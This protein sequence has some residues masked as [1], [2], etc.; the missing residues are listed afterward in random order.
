[1]HGISGRHL[2]NHASRLLFAQGAGNP[3]ASTNLRRAVRRGG[4]ASDEAGGGGVSG[5][6]MQARHGQLRGERLLIDAARWGVLDAMRSA[7]LRTVAA[8]TC[9]WARQLAGDA[10]AC[11]EWWVFSAALEYR[12][13]SGEAGDN[14]AKAKPPN[15]TASADRSVSEQVFFL[16]EARV[17]G[18]CQPQFDMLMAARASVPGALPTLVS[19]TPLSGPEFILPPRKRRAIRGGTSG[20]SPGADW[21]MTSRFQSAVREARALVPWLRMCRAVDQCAGWLSGVRLFLRGMPLDRAPDRIVEAADPLVELEGMA[22][23]FQAANAA[24][25]ATVLQRVSV[26][27]LPGGG[28]RWVARLEYL[29]GD[30]ARG[31]SDGGGTESEGTSEARPVLAGDEV[32]YAYVPADDGPNSRIRELTIEHRDAGRHLAAGLAMRSAALAILVR[33]RV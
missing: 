15:P 4:G 10:S 24:V 5:G 20:Q 3:G 13:D 26:A 30:G 12:H 7:A 2:A 14:R 31:G 9:D 27:H 8:P 17:E 18:D 28:W 11:R 32:A 23:L 1:M 22:E 19:R 29:D 6:A 21:E 33:E 25:E 16:I